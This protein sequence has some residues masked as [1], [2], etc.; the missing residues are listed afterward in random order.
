MPA[1][2]LGEPQES[3]E[4]LLQAES[5]IRQGK[6]PNLNAMHPYWSDLARLLQVYHYS[7][8]QSKAHQ[9]QIRH[10]RKRMHSDVYELYI[11]KRARRKV[12]SAAP[13]VLVPQPLF[14]PEALDTPAPP[15]ASQE[16]AS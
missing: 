16:E 11:D 5:D 12:A 13:K 2:P 15:N 7:L 6:R 1:M 10:I 14:P 3:I 4:L 8:S 9:H